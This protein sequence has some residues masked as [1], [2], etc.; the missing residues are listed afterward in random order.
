M[1]EPPPKRYISWN[2]KH[3]PCLLQT[4][5]L[6]SLNDKMKRE[7]DST[8]VFST[9]CAH[10]TRQHGFCGEM[11]GFWLLVFANQVRIH[12]NV[13]KVLSIWCYCLLKS[14]IFSVRV[15]VAPASRICRIFLPEW[16]ARTLDSCLNFTLYITLLRVIFIP[17]NLISEYFSFY[18]HS[19]LFV[20]GTE[21]RFNEIILYGINILVEN[22]GVGLSICAVVYS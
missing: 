11:E 17:N 20:D 4:Q 13:C 12:V 2:V 10:D 1:T 18:M 6:P 9:R 14:D 19:G 3:C 7:L 5:T 15:P 8:G 16:V 21:T 22:K